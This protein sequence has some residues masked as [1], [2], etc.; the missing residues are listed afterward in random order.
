MKKVY[1]THTYRDWTFIDRVT[2]NRVTTIIKMKNDWYS[3]NIDGVI[4]YAETAQKAYLAVRR[5][6]H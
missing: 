4:E 5:A 3:A 1:F 2:N 6:T